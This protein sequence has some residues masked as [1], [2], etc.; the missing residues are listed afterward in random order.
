LVLLAHSFFFHRDAKQLERHKPYP[1][2]TMVLAAQ[3][4][5]EAGR[6]VELFDANFAEGPEAFAVSGRLIE[7]GLPGDTPAVLVDKASLPDEAISRPAST[8]C[9]GGPHCAGGRA[10]DHPS[11]AS[12]PAAARCRREG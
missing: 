1:P 5:R 12:D 7:V 9:A 8:A 4:L 6:H 10:G 11:R 2:L 3:M